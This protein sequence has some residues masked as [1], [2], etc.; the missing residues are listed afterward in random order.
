MSVNGPSLWA[1]VA[2]APIAAWSLLLGGCGSNPSKAQCRTDPD[3][4][5]GACMM[6]TCL[7]RGTGVIAAAEVIPTLD[8]PTQ[9]APTELLELSLGGDAISLVAERLVIIAGTIA[10]ST[11]MDYARAGRVMTYV[12]S[13]IPGRSDLMLSADVAQVDGSASM[14]SFQLGVREGLIDTSATLWVFPTTKA[15]T[16]PPVPFVTMLTETLALQFPPLGSLL[17][18]GGTLLGLLDAPQVGYVARGTVVDGDWPVSNAA[19]TTA[20]GR[21]DL[22]LA[23]GAVPD[24]SS[25]VIELTPPAPDPSADN[26]LPSFVSDPVLFSSVVSSTTGPFH[27]PTFGTPSPMAFAVLA[28]DSQSMRPVQ[29]VTVKFHTAI[30]S[31][32]GGGQAVFDREKSTTADGQVSLVLLPGTATEPQLYQVTAMPPPGS[33]Y[34]LTCLSQVPISVGASDGETPTPTPAPGVIVLGRKVALHGTILGGDSLP[35]S[36]ISV[37]A[38]RLAST[39]DCAET[40]SLGPVSTTTSRSGGYTMLLD[41]GTYALDLEPAMG[42]PYPRLSLDGADAVT[43]MADSNVD[44]TLPAGQVVEGNVF[45]SDGM[46]VLAGAT[47]RFFDVLCAPDDCAGDH[48]IEPLLR[49]ETRSDANGH[50]RA[51]LPIPPAP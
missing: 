46:E 4:G 6:G 43:V 34:A 20:T 8:S 5:A 30:P 26:G 18:I 10:D 27:M 7:P 22:E 44:F 29:D 35:A 31:P 45:A 14:S 11:T 23:P 48:R 3:C 13:L 38:T 15:P 32:Q 17:G 42:A 25:I 51:V 21:F 37:T 9:S 24:G 1:N 47:V 33:P 36:G 12:K 41:P 28:G 49:A 2:L 16:Q 50:F 19:T 39:S 40:S